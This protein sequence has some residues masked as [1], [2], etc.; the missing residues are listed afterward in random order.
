MFRIYSIGL[1]R[2]V[3]IFNITAT[4][5]AFLLPYTMGNVC[6]CSRR[7]PS[8]SSA[9]FMISL[10]NVIRNAN[11]PINILTITSPVINPPNTKV[12]LVSKD[13]VILPIR[14]LLLKSYAYTIISMVHI[15]TITPFSI[16]IINPIIIAIINR[17]R[18]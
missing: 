12:R 8:T 5:I 16:D 2:H 10:D 4:I 7:S 6:A 1:S 9:S 3:S 14:H 17:I 11:N 15:I 13:T 18:L